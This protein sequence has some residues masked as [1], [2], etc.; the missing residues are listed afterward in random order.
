[1]KKKLFK[2][3]LFFIQ[4]NKVKLTKRKNGCIENANQYQRV[5][6]ILF[7]NKNNLERFYMYDIFMVCILKLKDICS[8]F[9]GK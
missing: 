8:N 7:I 3:S 6:I 9:I 4:I 2:L 1:M 5:T